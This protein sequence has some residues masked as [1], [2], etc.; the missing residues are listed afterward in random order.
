MTFSMDSK[1]TLGQ[2]AMEAVYCSL[3]W[4]VLSE[5]DKERWHDAAEAVRQLVEQWH[6]G[7]VKDF[8]ERP[9]SE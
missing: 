8:A 5:R 6:L 2:V 9:T 1:K 7:G 4:E 3:P